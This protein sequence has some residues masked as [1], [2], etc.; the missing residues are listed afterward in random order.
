MLSRKMTLGHSKIFTARLVLGVDLRLKPQEGN[1][2][3]KWTVCGC[4]DYSLKLN[5]GMA[6][7]C[8]TDIHIVN[9][10]YMISS[11]KLNFLISNN[12]NI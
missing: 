10:G 1:L 2:A 12:V 6:I 3:K 8:K 7:R 11:K 9:F 5:F 4:T